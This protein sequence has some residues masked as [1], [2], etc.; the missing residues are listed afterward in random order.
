MIGNRPLSEQLK[1]VNTIKKSISSNAVATYLIRAFEGVRGIRKLY[2]NDT[3]LAEYLL[4]LSSYLDH[5][6]AN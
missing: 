5:M 2:D 3:I 6:Q 4:G 1:K